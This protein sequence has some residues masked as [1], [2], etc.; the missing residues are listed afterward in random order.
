MLSCLKFQRVL[1]SLNYPLYG[2]LVLFYGCNIILFCSN[3]LFSVCFSLWFSFKRLSSKGWQLSNICSLLRCRLIFTLGILHTCVY[4]TLLNMFLTPKSISSI[5][6]FGVSSPAN[7][8]RIAR[9]GKCL[10][11]FSVQVSSHL[12]PRLSKFLWK[13]QKTF[14]CPA[15]T[16]EESVA[17]WSRWSRWEPSELN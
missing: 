1:S 11:G 14:L 12:H 15:R 4:G 3:F 10:G 13:K 6:C 8:V 17:V 2:I 7:G 16:R 9:V 5:S